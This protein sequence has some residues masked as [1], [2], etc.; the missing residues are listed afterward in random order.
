MT[1]V[2]EALTGS[3]PSSSSWVSEITPKRPLPHLPLRE[4]WRD[5][6]HEQNAGNARLWKVKENSLRW[7]KEKI[8]HRFAENFHNV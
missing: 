4:I 3:T 7:L 1:K 8:G 6:L 2:D 5:L